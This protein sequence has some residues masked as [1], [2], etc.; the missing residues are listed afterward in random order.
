MPAMTLIR[1]G[2]AVSAGAVTWDPA[3]KSSILDLSGGNLTVTSNAAGTNGN[4][5]HVRATTSKSSGKWHWEVDFGT[6]ECNIGFANSSFVLDNTYMGQ[7]DGH[8]FG[9]YANGDVTIVNANTALGATA[10]A[11]AT[12]AVEIDIDAELVWFAINGDNWNN[13]GGADPAAGTG[14]ISFA[15]AQSGPWFPLVY[16]YPVGVGEAATANFTS[17]G[18]SKT[19]S[20]GFSA[21]G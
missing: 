11:S 8:S 14:G 20:S 10:P 5:Y 2:A 16:A 12:V 13:S 21:W 15:A 7:G 9:L 4:G 1:A 17:V 19:I 6:L 18:V 3:N